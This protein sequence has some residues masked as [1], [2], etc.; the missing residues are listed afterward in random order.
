V[1]VTQVVE[2]DGVVEPSRSTAWLDTRH[3]VRCSRG[4]P[5]RDVN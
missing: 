3:W 1:S 2:R 5:M 4:A